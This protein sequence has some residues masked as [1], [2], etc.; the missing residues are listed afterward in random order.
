VAGDYNVN[1]TSA[2][3]RNAQAWVKRRFVFAAHARGFELGHN[4]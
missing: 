3:A 2:D 1:P 4:D